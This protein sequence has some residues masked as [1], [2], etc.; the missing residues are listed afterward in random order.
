MTKSPL[1]SVILPAYNAEHYIELSIQSILEQ[2]YQNFELIIV[3]D[4]S[5]DNTKERILAFS[6]ERIIYLENKKNCG[7]IPTLNSAISQ[8]KGRFIA[9]MD[10]DDIALKHRLKYQV[11][12]L[13]NNPDYILCGGAAYLMDKDGQTIG[14]M[15]R[16]STNESIRANLLFTNP[17]IHPTIMI[18]TEIIKKYLYREDALHCEDLEL[19][20]RLS[21]NKDN[22]LANLPQKLIKY[23]IHATNVS[24]T[25][26]KFQERTRRAYFQESIE[27]LMGSINQD[28]L[29]L[30]F[31]SFEQN[32][33]LNKKTVLRAKKWIERLS[34]QNKQLNQFDSFSFNSLLLSRWLVLCLK[35]KNLFLFPFTKLPWYNPGILCNA[36]KM[37]FLKGAL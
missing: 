35:S 17:F 25:H 34:S 24:V 14:N 37:L 9:R 21:K 22:K 3:N 27:T 6:D 7:L 18:R 13:E 19:W 23:R 16:T 28:E 31:L 36:V 8:S 15:C 29:N 33:R 5:T 30:H 2:S 11:H 20:I 1:V 26:K 32:D 10:A 4:G 12:F